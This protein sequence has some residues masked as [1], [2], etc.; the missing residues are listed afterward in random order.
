MVVF[1]Q[2]LWWKAARVRTA[3]ILAVY[4][5]IGELV[6][7]ESR[8]LRYS[9]E[10]RIGCLMTIEIRKPELEALIVER[11]RSGEF[12]SIEDVLMQA[13]KGSSIPPKKE[14]RSGADLVA[15]MQ[16]SPSKEIDLEPGRGPL[17]VRDIAF[18]TLRLCPAPGLDFD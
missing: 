12:E 6:E 15:A 7:T 1:N 14:T 5:S 4:G 9:K 2:W 10:N 13:L 17:P 3:Q 11:L 8:L 16:N 18:S